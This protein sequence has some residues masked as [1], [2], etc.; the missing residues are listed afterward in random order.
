VSEQTSGGELQ[1]WD[2]ES[3]SIFLNL[4]ESFVP[5][6]AEQIATLTDLIPARSDEPFTAVE[7]GAGEGAL[8]RA[9]LAAYPACH[10]VAYD[11]SEAMRTRMRTTLASY[12][13]RLDV[14]PFELAERAWRAGLPSPL[15]GVLSS[16]AIHHLT[17]DEK[18][19]LF[20]DLA[21]RLEAGGALLIADIVEPASPQIARVYARQ[22]DAIVREQ[23]L[24]RHGDLRDYQQFLDLKWNYFAHDYGSTETT[25]FPS[26]LSDQ[27]RWLAEAGFAP[28]DCFWLRAGHA[29]FGGYVHL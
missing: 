26:L 3:S 27:L 25:D 17:G 6:R 7:L 20:Q 15:R 8:A 1:G 19:T 21:P 28:V 16:L 9:V 13:D 22:Y 4:A 12:G 24:A 10:Y 11:G 14:R 23:S 18:R 5:A 29:I 2:E